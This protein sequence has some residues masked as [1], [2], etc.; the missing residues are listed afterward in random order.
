MRMHGLSLVD[1]MVGLAIGMIAMLVILNVMVMFDARRRATTGSS[2]AQANAVFATSLLSRELRLAG[3]GLGPAAGLGCTVHRSA[4]STADTRF[5]LVPALIDNGNGGNPDQLSI[6]AAGE[7]ALPP[8]RLITSY[9]NNGGELTVDST[10]GIFPNTQLLLQSVGS[11]DCALLS[12]LSVSVGAYTVQPV[13]AGN[14]LPGAVFGTDSPVLNVGTLMH[15][16]YSVDANQQ[17]RVESFDANS[18]IWRASTLA[19]GV[20]NLQVQ[21]GFDA[22]AGAQT[23]PQVTR[24]S[25]ELIDADGNGITGNAG[26]WQRMLAVRLAV[27]TRSAQRKDEG[28]DVEAPSWMAGNAA[29]GELEATT[30]RVDQLSDWRCW[31]YRVLQTEVPLR[32]QLWG[33]Q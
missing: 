4:V 2:D 18:G 31:R 20:V 24:W 1:L 28:C 14:V 32:N 19:D 12:V 13:I 7:Q 27:V 8:A 15:R 10:L 5:L 11:A 16:R 30:I 9:T 33:N 22:R 3:H 25:D 26:D 29:T 6:L 17:L 23:T 21:Y